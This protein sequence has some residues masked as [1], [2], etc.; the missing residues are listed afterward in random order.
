MKNSFVV[1]RNDCE[2]CLPEFRNHDLIYLFISTGFR[3][4]F[5]DIISAFTSC[6]KLRSRYEWKPLGLHDF[7][8][9]F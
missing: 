3:T 8:S 5:R 9:L 1:N 4:N 2:R 6:E 7:S